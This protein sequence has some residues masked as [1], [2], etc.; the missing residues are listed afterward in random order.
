ME[1]SRKRAKHPKGDEPGRTEPK[2]PGAKEPSGKRR[3][4]LSPEAWERIAKFGTVVVETAPK[5][6][7]AIRTR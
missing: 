3:K 7:D 5:V 2:P 1:I 6:I 4:G